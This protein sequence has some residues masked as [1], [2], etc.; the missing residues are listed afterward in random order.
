[1]TSLETAPS[2][3]G[4]RRIAIDPVTRVEGHGKVTILLDAENRVHQVRLHIV[5]F[6]GFEAFV[7]GRPYWE[8][9]VMVQRLCG[10]CPVSHHLAAVKAMDRIAG[11][12]ALT[13]TAE[14]LRRLMHYGQIAQSHA[15]H[16]FHLASPDLLLGFDC[17]ATRRNI[18]GVVAAAP[19]I[20]LKGVKL[21]K[22]GQEVI[23][24]T[25]GKRIHGTGAIPG[26][27][28]KALTPEERDELR[29]DLDEHV[30]WA[31]EAVA[32]IRRL[33][34][35]APDFYAGFGSAPSHT[36]SLVAPDGAMD[37]Y[38]GGLR[39]RDLNGAILFDHVDPAAYHE[40]IVEIVKPW[41]YMKFPHIAA[42]GAEDGWYKVGPLARL[43][44]VDR[45]PSPLA[46]AERQVFLA[47]GGGRPIAGALMTHWAR[48][49]ELLHALE[50]IRDLLDDPEITGTDLM[51]ERGARAGEAV[52][53]IEAPRGTLIHHY[54][55]G[56]DDLVSWCNLIVSTT[57]NN[58][59]MNEAIRAVARDH[60]DG[61][62]VTEPLLNHVEVAIRAYDPCL[63]CATHAL[64]RMPL[65][66]DL[67]DA[68]GVTI[69][70]AVRNADP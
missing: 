20:A 29:R 34:G 7:E 51:A 63:S 35:A 46:E 4:L 44:T 40:R 1:M 13:P 5:E 31:V 11:Y 8:V 19:D 28:N 30:G 17:E 43:Q 60:L 14:K 23:R 18:V 67:V 36:M 26:G 42:L 56:D 50:V 64:G 45:M 62:V 61:R 68:D 6:R 59:A 58:Q 65:I 25:A 3:T 39:A 70:R 10:I 32:L 38:D 53:I 69:S 54:R 48:L 52:G 41:S 22:F 12:G 9:P 33:A 24:H 57:H 37:L 27:V 16:F 21:R 2:K 55:V 49:I 47:A 15:V 66:V